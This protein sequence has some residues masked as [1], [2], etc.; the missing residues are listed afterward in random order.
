MTFHQEYLVLSKMMHPNII[1]IYD[2]FNEKNYYVLVLKFCENGSLEDYLI[3]NENIPESKLMEWAKQILG[4]LSY[5]HQNN[6]SHH[7]IKPSNILI[8]SF[9]R[10]KLAD[11]GIAQFLQKNEKSM[12][13]GGSVAFIAPEQFLKVPY[14][15]FK[16][17]AWSFGVTLYM[18]RFHGRLPFFGNNM[19]E[20]HSLM[21]K[22]FFEIPDH[23]SYEFRQIFN[24]ALDPNVETRWSVSQLLDYVCK[25]SSGVTKHCVPNRSRSL[26][27]GRSSSLP[28]YEGHLNMMPSIIVPSIPRK[29]PRLLSN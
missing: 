13:Y 24:H 22:G 2:Y 5:M 4:A 18:L 27:N 1:N 11:F 9:G 7:D 10:I 26:I 14:D 8:D 23:C 28:R 16:A 3:Q 21:S 25:T 17:D 15:S 6:A 29:I 12:I 20:I 19:M